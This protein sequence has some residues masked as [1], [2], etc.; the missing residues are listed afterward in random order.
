M[1]RMST[2]HI[3]VLL[4]IGAIV[5][6][7]FLESRPGL[8][9]TLG[10]ADA[11]GFAAIGISD[12]DAGAA[13]ATA[14][15]GIAVG[16]DAQA[17]TQDAAHPCAGGSHAIDCGHGNIA[18]GS[19]RERPATSPSRS[20]NSARPAASIARRLAPMQMRLGPAASPPATPQ[21]PAELFRSPSG[22][23]RPRPAARLPSAVRRVRAPA[24]PSP[25]DRA[26]PRP[27]G[28]RLRPVPR[29]T[30]P[31]TI[32]SP[33]APRPRPLPARRGTS[34]TTRSPSVM[35][36]RR[37]AYPIRPSEPRPE[38]R[39]SVALP[40]ASKPWHKPAGLRSA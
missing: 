4:A 9:E 30:P 13:T 7:Q 32:P 5:P 24:I 12:S 15:G 26:A 33:S 23:T 29:P 6:M 1:S 8:A 17:F 18:M 2:S 28:V 19:R 20:A 27:A 31:E 35:Q 25:W 11:K 38:L 40:T 37:S 39:T 36:R 14:I 10:N 3:A 16:P 34:R 22:P 21:P